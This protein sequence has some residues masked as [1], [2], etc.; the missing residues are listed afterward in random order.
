MSPCIPFRGSDGKI[1]GFLCGPRHMSRSCAYCSRVHTKL[2]DFKMGP[3]KTCDAPLCTSCTVHTEPDRDIC[4][5]HA[6]RGDVE[7]QE[8][9][10]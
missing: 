6:L 1:S 3:G 9:K 7:Y 4:R 10:P 5:I 8:A 2:C